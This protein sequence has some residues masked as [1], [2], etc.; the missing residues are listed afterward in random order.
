MTRVW[1][2]RQ[3]CHKVGSDNH[4][5]LFV[6]EHWEEFGRDAAY[7]RDIAQVKDN[8]SFRTE[9]LIQMMK[10]RD[11]LIYMPEGLAGDQ[12]LAKYEQI[13]GELIG[14]ATVYHLPDYAN[15]KIKRIEDAT[16]RRDANRT[17]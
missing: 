17:E 8:V 15:K 13:R 2:R 14:L 6:N 9:I 12:R 7:W 4:F 3:E 10:L 11:S 1:R 16:R 5:E